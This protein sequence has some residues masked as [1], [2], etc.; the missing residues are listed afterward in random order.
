M[1]RQPLPATRNMQF[2]ARQQHCVPTH[3]L[4]HPNQTSK[5]NRLG[6]SM[7]AG[8]NAANHGIELQLKAVTRAHNAYSA[9]IETI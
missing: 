3:G 8:K 9:G 6:L 2:R 7:L 4:G 1:F 5:R